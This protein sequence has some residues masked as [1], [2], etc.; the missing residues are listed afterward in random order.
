MTE[1]PVKPWWIYLILCRDNSLYCGISCDVQ[2]RFEQHRT[3]K[4]AKYTK[5]R[6]VVKIVWQSEATDLS[7]AM[8]AEMWI[9]D[10]KRDQKDALV[11]GELPCGGRLQPA[12]PVAEALRMKRT[13]L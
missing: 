7:T 4:G 11:R 8:S 9:K 1:R 10:L 5:H 6:G 13:Y 3:G 2:R 12:S